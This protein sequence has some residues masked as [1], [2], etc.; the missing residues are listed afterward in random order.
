MKREVSRDSYQNIND[1]G[2]IECNHAEGVRMQFMLVGY[3]FVRS[4]DHFY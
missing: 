2:T 3:C 4:I 1:K